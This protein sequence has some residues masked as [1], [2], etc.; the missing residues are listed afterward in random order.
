MSGP[1]AGGPM[2]RRRIR[3]VLMRVAQRPVLPPA[4]RFTDA[5]EERLRVAHKT[6]DVGPVEQAEVAGAARVSPLGAAAGRPAQA[7]TSTRRRLVDGAGRGW[8]VAGLAAVAVVVPLLALALAGDLVAPGSN[9][10]LSDAADAEFIVP[11]GPARPAH[12]GAALPEGTIIRTGTAGSVTVGGQTLGPDS[13]AIVVDGHLRPLPEGVAQ[14]SAGGPSP[15]PKKSGERGS[16]SAALA[17]LSQG[18]AKGS[19]A[20]TSGAPSEAAPSVQGPARPTTP[21]SQPSGRPPSPAPIRLEAARAGPGTVG[22]RWSRYAGPGFSG[23]AVLRV[24]GPAEPRYPQDAIRFTGDAG[25]TTYADR[26]APRSQL[27]Y[28]VMALDNRGRVVA[29]SEVVT[30]PPA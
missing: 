19:R 10:R 1:E 12:A 16:G 6:R 27:R 3:R 14:P 8:T 28:R 23:Y 26:A 24:A 11:G 18:T 25:D 30:L 22:L 2:S 5:L 29:A 21:P 20:G 15:A 13:A 7:P 4:P 17:Q 9:V